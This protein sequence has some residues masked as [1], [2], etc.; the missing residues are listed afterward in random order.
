VAGLGQVGEDVLVGVDLQALGD[1]GL[2]VWFAAVGEFDRVPSASTQTARPAAST[3]LMPAA[4]AV[5]M[6]PSSSARG[7]RP[8]EC[9]RRRNASSRALVSSAA[10][11]LVG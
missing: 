4:G 8:L 11:R 3:G 1:V 7:L 10:A 6:R 9:R 2:Q 5:W